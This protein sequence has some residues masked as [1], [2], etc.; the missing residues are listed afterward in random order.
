MREIKLLAR[1][2]L[3][4]VGIILMLGLSGCVNSWTGRD[5]EDVI[6]DQN[7]RIE[8]KFGLKAESFSFFTHEGLCWEVRLDCFI[9]YS[10]S[11]IIA[12]TGGPSMQYNHVPE[13]E[14]THFNKS[15]YGHVKPS[16][17]IDEDDLIYDQLI[18]FTYNDLPFN[19]EYGNDFEQIFKLI[20][21]AGLG[22]AVDNS[23]FTDT[24]LDRNG[25]EVEYIINKGRKIGVGNITSGDFMELMLKSGCRRRFQINVFSQ[26][27]SSEQVKPIADQ[28]DDQ[29]EQ[30]YNGDLLSVSIYTLNYDQNGKILYGDKCIDENG[31]F[32]VSN[33]SDFENRDYQNI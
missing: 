4:L 13:R 33:I 22:Y 1:F 31:E 10:Q 32:S 23:S 2:R 18:D 11:S 24:C 27:L 20:D 21:D 26:S 29:V 25:D 12:P 3:V 28:L 19:Q 16:Q 17:K 5:I 30:F 6:A 9:P 7:K 15:Y 8:N 14:Q